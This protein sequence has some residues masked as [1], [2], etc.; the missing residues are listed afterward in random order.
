MEQLRLGLPGLSDSNVYA[1]G[2]TDF[3]IGAHLTASWLLSRVRCK[4]LV[5]GYA[6]IVQTGMNPACKQV[7][8]TEDRYAISGRLLGRET[9]RLSS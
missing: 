1:L 7:K 5:S 4:S 3:G 6:G 8:H 2:L 9:V